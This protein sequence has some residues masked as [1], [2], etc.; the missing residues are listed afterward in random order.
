[1]ATKALENTWAEISTHI[2]ELA[3][4]RGLEEWEAFRDWAFVEI[5][6]GEALSD[7]ISEVDL[8]SGHTRIDGP[9]DLEVDGFFVHE[10]ERL[11]SLFQA[12]HQKKSITRKAID[13][14]IGVPQR[15]LNADLVGAG[16][17]AEVK[18]LHSLLNSKLV[19]DSYGLSLV[20]ATSARLQPRASAE[21]DG[22]RRQKR[23]HLQVIGKRFH[24]SHRSASL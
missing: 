21:V 24:G 23:I 5:F 13:S 16:N 2:S 14:F 15:V 1:M 18:Y 7:S 9:D 4:Q 22:F 3:E 12:K 11:V 20:F 17:N 8:A 10:E 6:R 19:D